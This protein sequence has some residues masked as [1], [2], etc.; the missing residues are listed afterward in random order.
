MITAVYCDDRSSSIFVKSV[1]FCHINVDQIV[2]TSKLIYLL[3][4]DRWLEKNKDRFVIIGDY[5]L[6]NE[7]R[8]SRTILFFIGSLN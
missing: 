5:V 1:R 6:S 2:M 4:F 8:V 3:Y 7:V